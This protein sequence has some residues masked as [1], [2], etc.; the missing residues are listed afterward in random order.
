MPKQIKNANLILLNNPTE[1]IEN[2]NRRAYNN[3]VR[4]IH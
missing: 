3:I 4:T 2:F 1:S